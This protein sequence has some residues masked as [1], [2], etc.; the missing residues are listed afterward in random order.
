MLNIK[1]IDIVKQLEDNKK[2]LTNTL[3]HIKTKQS[4]LQDELNEVRSDLNN[5]EA[6]IDSINELTVNI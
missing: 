2:I 4:E 5:I 1:Y 3:A 6:A